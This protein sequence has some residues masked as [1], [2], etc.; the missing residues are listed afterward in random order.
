MSI[1][2]QI[3]STDQLE[4]HAVQTLR[5]WFP[6]YLNEIELQRAITGLDLPPPRSYEVSDELTD[7]PDP[8][9]LPAVIVI[10]PGMNVPPT[11]EGDGHFTGY[12]TLRTAVA[13]SASDR[14]ST[15]RNNKIYTAAARAILLQKKS[16]GDWCSGVQFLNERYDEGED[17]RGRTFAVGTLEMVYAV[18][19]I[20][21]ARYGPAVPIP[22]VPDALPGSSWGTVEETHLTVNQI[23]DGT[24]EL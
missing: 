9:Q 20:V 11:M 18:P 17:D 19:G 3:L 15:R 5:T 13:N 16:L 4:D 8:A 23:L 2:G 12:F 7:M 21:N 14:S 10:S 24:G 1:F 22:P 6:T